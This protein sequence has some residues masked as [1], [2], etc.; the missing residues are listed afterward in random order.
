MRPMRRVG[1]KGA[2]HIAPGNTVESFD[3]AIEAGVDMI[4][5]DVLPERLD[6]TGELFLAHTYF[7]LELD[8]VVG[9]VGEVREALVERVRR[10]RGGVLPVVGEQQ[11]AGAVGALGQDVELDHVDARLELSLIHI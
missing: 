4:E 3:A 11:L 7:D 2:D 1:H 10:A 6:G 9:G 8:A 5:F